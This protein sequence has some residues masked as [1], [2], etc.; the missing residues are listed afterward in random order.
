MCIPG[1]SKENNHWEK[2]NKIPASLKKNA[3]TQNKNS[4]YTSSMCCCDSNFHGLVQAS[5]NVIVNRYTNIIE[6]LRS[7]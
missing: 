1:N 4:K 3:M 7:S 6:K 2:V 5:K